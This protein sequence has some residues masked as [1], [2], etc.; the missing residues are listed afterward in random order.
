[1][2]RMFGRQVFSY[3]FKIIKKA[4]TPSSLSTDIVVS[5]KSI[6]PALFFQQFFVISRTVGVDL[7]EVMR[8]EFVTH[9]IILREAILRS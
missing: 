4:Q 9:I 7:E 5:G 6:D 8:C 2:S 3:A 1:M